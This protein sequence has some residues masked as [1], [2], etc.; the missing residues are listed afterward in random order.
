MLFILFI[1]SYG[2]EL[3]EKAITDSLIEVILL[4]SRNIEVNLNISGESLFQSVCIDGY[5]FVHCMMDTS[6][7]LFKFKTG[8]AI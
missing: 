5:H 6:L 8:S 1:A 2:Q 4:F 7:F 3:V